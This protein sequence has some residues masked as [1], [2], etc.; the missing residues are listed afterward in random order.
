VIYQHPLAYVLGLE[1]V[2]LLR[3]FIGESDR[4][5]VEARIAEI[6]ALLADEA[7][8]DAAVEVDRVDSVAGYRLWS[9]TYD[10]PN[11]A[12]DIDEPIV[13]QIL[14]ELPAGVALD[15]ACGTGRYS[16]ELAERGH[17]VVGV[18]SSPEM[19]VLARARVP[20]AEFLH[21]DLHRLPV[22]DH[23][24]DLVV[25]ALALTHLPSVAPVITEF[26]RVLRPGGHVVISDMHPE[27]VL[28]GSIP[29]VR[30]PDGRPGQLN[31]CRHLV[32]DYL[33]AALAV[34]LHPRRCEEPVPPRTD[35]TE[36]PEPPTGRDKLG[37]WESW[38]WT[39]GD[40]VPE[41]RRAANAGTPSMLIWHFQSAGR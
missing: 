34:G 17:R 22:A 2:A 24:V 25:C 26:A 3:A 8:T 15:A 6:R 13:R 40:L 16:R 5:F 35:V 4:D 29:S 27:T 20:A 36:P 41:A 21:G 18:D 11:S 14:D 39:L 23:S 33:R 30:G 19:L 32:G 38:P 31:G 10:Q 37:P 12:F 1:G 9:T 28:R 7:F